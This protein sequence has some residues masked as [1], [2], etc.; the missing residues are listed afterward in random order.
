MNNAI[1]LHSF[2]AADR[3]RTIHL[4][5]ILEESKKKIYQNLGIE[6]YFSK[7]YKIWFSYRYKVEHNSFD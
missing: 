4:S 7:I 5:S 2:V 1:D 3:A 6:L